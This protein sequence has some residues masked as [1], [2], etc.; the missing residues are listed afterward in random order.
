[1]SQPVPMRLAV[2]IERAPDL[3]TNRTPSRLAKARLYA[4]SLDPDDMPPIMRRTLALICHGHT[5]EEI[6]RET[7]YALNTVKDRAKALLGIFDARNRTH[8]AAL[9]VAQGYVDMSQAA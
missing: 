7:Y 5:N 4:P 9:A 1:M 3:S 6:A 2:A 8:L